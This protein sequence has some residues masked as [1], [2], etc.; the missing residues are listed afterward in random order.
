M[1]RVAKARRAEPVA[2][3]RKEAE[4]EEEGEER[5]PGWT[6]CASRA[7]CS[8]SLARSLAFG[9][10]LSCSDLDQSERRV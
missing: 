6:G 8:R 5:K 7:V 9:L 1:F 3:E 10:S 2:G 4:D